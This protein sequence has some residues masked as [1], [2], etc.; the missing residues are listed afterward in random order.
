M[1]TKHANPGEVVDLMTWA[2]D[3]P[4]ARTKAIV[5]T[6]ELELIRI[7]LPAGKE[8]PTH[9]VAGPIIAH[10]IQ[11]KAM[12]TAMGACQHVKPGQLIHLVSEEPHAVKAI[13]DTVILLTIFFRR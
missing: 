13:E 4:E 9:K 7:Y 12:F 8:L 10:C 2:D 11:G 3:L 6:D 5:K 1:A